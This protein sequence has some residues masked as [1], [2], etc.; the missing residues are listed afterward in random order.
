MMCCSASGCP[1]SSSR[2]KPDF[3]SQQNS[4]SWAKSLLDRRLGYWAKGGLI[5]D[6]SYQNWHP[7][8]QSPAG[9]WHACSLVRKDLVAG[10]E[11][12]KGGLPPLPV[13]AHHDRRKG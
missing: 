7:G 4:T 8:E 11:V 5:S 12:G 2:R 10:S 1:P 9:R 13:S 6:V 3:C